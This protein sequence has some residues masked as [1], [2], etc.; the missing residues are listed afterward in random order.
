MAD[1]D[2]LDLAT[3]YAQ[4]AVMLTVIGFAG[5]GLASI[6][7][8]ALF[9]IALSDPLDYPEWVDALIG[10]F[11]VGSVGW[12]ITF[13]VLAINAMRRHSRHHRRIAA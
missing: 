4:R 6:I 12:L 10:F 13:L 5:A 3:Y 9:Y 8:W 2:P 11:A 1:H 7:L